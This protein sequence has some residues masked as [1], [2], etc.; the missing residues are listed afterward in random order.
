MRPL[1]E[2]VALTDQI[3]DLEYKLAQ[4]TKENEELREALTDATQ[5]AEAC[6]AFVDEQHNERLMGRRADWRKAANACHDEI[7][8]RP[9]EWRKALATQSTSK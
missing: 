9:D 4:R 5:T 3:E 8:S 6:K 1:T 7:D 2:T